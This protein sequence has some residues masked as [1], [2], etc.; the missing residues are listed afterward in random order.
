MGEYLKFYVKSA[1]LQS[2]ESFV[3]TY[4]YNIH[5][6]TYVRIYAYTYIRIQICTYVHTYIC[7]NYVPS[8]ESNFLGSSCFSAIRL[9]DK[10]AI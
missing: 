3:F 4:V 6:C 10:P 2:I 8:F 9:V 5:M 1:S 7:I